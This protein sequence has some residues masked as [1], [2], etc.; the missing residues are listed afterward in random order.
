MSHKDRETGPD[1]LKD[2]L[3]AHGRSPTEGPPN[4]EPKGTWRILANST[5]LAIVALAVATAIY[6]LS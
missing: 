4:A 5:A 6:F 3:T 1:V 2:D